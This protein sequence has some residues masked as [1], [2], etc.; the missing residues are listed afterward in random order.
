MKN[1][2]ISAL[3]RCIGYVGQEPVL[4]ASSIRH[5]IMQGC[6]G[7]SKEDFNKACADAQLSFVD[8]LP[9]KYNTFVGAGGGQLSGGQKQRI[10]IARALLK[11]ASFLFLDEATSALDNTSEKMIQQTIDPGHPEEDPSVFPKSDITEAEDSIGA[12]SESGL[13]IVSIA[14]RLSRVGRRRN[15]THEAEAA[16]PKRRRTMRGMACAGD[17]AIDSGTVRNSDLIYVLMRGSLVES[18]NHTQLMEK[19]GSYFALV[20]AQESSQKAEEAEANQPFGWVDGL[21]LHRLKRGPLPH[22]HTSAMLVRQ[23]SEHSGESENARVAREKKEEKEREAQIQK[24]YKVPMARLF[25]SSVRRAAHAAAGDVRCGRFVCYARYT[26]WYTNLKAKNRSAWKATTRARAEHRGYNQPEWP[27]LVPAVL[28]ALIDGAAMPL[29]T[30]A[31]V[32]SMEGFFKE[33]EQMREELQM[34]GRRITQLEPTIP[35]WR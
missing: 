7:A 28:G 33:K 12:N 32:G 24:N 16:P 17:G 13:G 31:L 9:E 35:A 1:F 27:Y 21:P 25:S 34:P 14:H 22:D 4:F 2:K 3:R 26:K 11:K 19:K 29:C 5:N 15:T 30:V 6:P 23:M 20:A 8:N 18:G 10:A